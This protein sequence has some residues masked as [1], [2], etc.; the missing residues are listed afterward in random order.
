MF[1][2]LQDQLSRLFR[3]GNTTVRGELSETSLKTL[4][5][6]LIEADVGLDAIT[7]LQADIRVRFA[8][9]AALGRVRETDFADLVMHALTDFLGGSSA[10][11]GIPP[12]A[13]ADNDLEAKSLLPNETPTREGV[14]PLKL[15]MKDPISTVMLVGLQGSG[16]TTTAAKLAR[17]CAQQ[18]KA[19]MVVS[20]DFRRPAG[21]EQLR[22]MAEQSGIPAFQD[23]D[24][25]IPDTGP[26][27][28]KA[29]AQRHARVLDFATKQ[30]CNL[31]ILDTAGRTTTNEEDIAALKTLHGLVKPSETLFV[32]DAMQGQEAVATALLFAETVKITGNVLTRV[33][34]DARGGGAISMRYA[35][36]RPIKFIGTSER[37]DGIEVFHPERIA[38]RLL[39]RGDMEGLIERITGDLEATDDAET[40]GS[41]TDLSGMRS[42]LKKLLKLG[43][44]GGL[45][46]M[47]PGMGR[48]REQVSKFDDNVILRQIAIINSMT[49][50]ERTHPEQLLASRKKRVAKGS[51]VATSEVNKTLKQFWMM[52]NAMKAMQHVDQ[53]TVMEQV[54]AGNIPESMA[55]AIGGKSGKKAVSG[56]K[57]MKKA[58]RW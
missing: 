12:A 53:D 47:L 24:A 7:A 15:S 3:R 39:D 19:P 6:V 10:S 18:G 30:G 8:D 55:G 42:H 48:L 11:D 14:W 9:V 37:I 16:K 46:G 23:S 35:T 27:T 57:R 5:D 21:M 25:A 33:D 2:S 45:L 52:Q 56:L 44:A 29:L 31:I 58:R 51:G 50:F 49:P 4:R 40:A 38:Q 17:W 22:L 41:M 54:A 28:E 20:Y 34:G 32:G 13:G 36:K 26:D 1:D 43:G